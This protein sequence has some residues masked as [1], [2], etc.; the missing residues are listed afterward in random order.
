[1]FLKDE[2]CEDESRLNDVLALEVIYC[3]LCS[4]VCASGDNTDQPVVQEE[5]GD[6]DDDEGEWIV[7][8]TSRPRTQ[9]VRQSDALI[10]SRSKSQSPTPH[11][12]NSVKP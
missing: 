11:S 4:D 6:D 3:S 10:Q 2:S 7:L 8:Q 12:R 5:E 9:Q 1:M